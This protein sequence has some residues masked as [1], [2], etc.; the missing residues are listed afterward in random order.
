ML[1]PNRRE[2]NNAG[3][4][5]MERGREEER[6]REGERER[7]EEDG[8]LEAD[9]LS[10]TRHR[11]IGCIHTAHKLSL[12]LSSSPAAAGDFEQS[13]T[14]QQKLLTAVTGDGGRKNSR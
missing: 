10:C 5:R 12:S 11:Q 1:D 2:K 14:T 6:E 8:G 3:G 13:K 9:L 4:E 7:E